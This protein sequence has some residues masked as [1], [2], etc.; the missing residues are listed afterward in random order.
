MIVNKP[1]KKKKKK[2]SRYTIFIMIMS[3]IFTVIL[4]KLIYLQVIKHD[5]Y[6]ERADT[7]STKFVSEK[8]P[9]GI[10]YDSKGNILATNIQTYTMTYTSTNETNQSF[11]ETIDK[12]NQILSEN[13]E[14]IIDDFLLKIDENNNI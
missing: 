12:V 7:T 14:S 11:F 4:S 3:I 5:D 8:A 10:I 1:N 2:L 6:K 9:R 13:N